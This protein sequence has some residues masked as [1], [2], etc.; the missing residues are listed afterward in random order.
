MP[1]SAAKAILEQDINAALHR[2]KNSGKKK[3][4]GDK[5]EK[6][7]LDVFAMDLAEAIHKYT[8]SAEVIVST[9]TTAVTGTAAPLA[10][11]GA[12]MVVGIGSGAGKG[13]LA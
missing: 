8:M 4:G 5:Q 6:D 12:A 3:H 13:N 10:P 7:I 2:M 9:V 1:L 11:T